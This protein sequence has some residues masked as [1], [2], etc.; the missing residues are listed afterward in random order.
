MVF[1]C[2]YR[3]APRIVEALTIVEPE[4]VVRW[5]RAGFRCVPNHRI[6]SGVHAIGGMGLRASTIGFSKSDAIDHHP[7]ATPSVMPTNAATMKPT[8]TRSKLAPACAKSEPS[9]VI[10]QK[11]AKSRL[12][13][14]RR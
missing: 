6:A 10:S 3:I 8:T 2:L 12:G 11:V 14:G 4:T 1:V 7:R 13:G 5:H 9:S